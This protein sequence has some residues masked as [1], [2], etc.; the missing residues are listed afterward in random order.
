[1]QKDFC[2]P[3]YL[4]CPACLPLKFSIFIANKSASLTFVKTFRKL[5]SVC[6]FLAHPGRP[7]ARGPALPSPL[8]AGEFGPLRPTH[9]WRCE[10]GTRALKVASLTLQS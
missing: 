9:L 5:L 10:P 6:L 2:Q 3:L 1:M 7:A 8:S 4:S